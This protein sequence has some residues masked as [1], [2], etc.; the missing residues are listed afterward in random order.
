ML[1]TDMKGVKIG[2]SASK[3]R[4]LCIIGSPEFYQSHMGF[5]WASSSTAW[6]NENS[7]NLGITVT[8]AKH[9]QSMHWALMSVPTEGG[10]G[11][12]AGQEGGHK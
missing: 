12:E 8:M 2:S 11:A 3:T 10:G 7:F 4:K 6:L 1:R 5:F 9:L